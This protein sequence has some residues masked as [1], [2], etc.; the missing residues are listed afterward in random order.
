M[1]DAFGHGGSDAE[2]LDAATRG[3][4]WSWP[5]RKR[6]DHDEPAFP[7]I[8]AARTTHGWPDGDN[9]G[10]ADGTALAAFRRPPESTAG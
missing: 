2:R 3:N 7:G 6:A 4:V 10:H 1:G 8:A 9:N 5:N